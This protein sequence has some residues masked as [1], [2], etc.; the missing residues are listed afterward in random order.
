MMLGQG[1]E[2]Y[3]EELLRDPQCARERGSLV[4]AD[5]AGFRAVLGSALK[6]M[7]DQDPQWTQL[8]PSGICMEQALNLL[9]FPPQS[10]FDYSV[11]PIPRSD[12]PLLFAAAGRNVDLGEQETLR[13]QIAL[14][15]LEL[16]P[17]A[18]KPEYPNRDT[19]YP[20]AFE[21]GTQGTG[22]ILFSKRGHKE[23]V[24]F[25]SP[26]RPLCSLW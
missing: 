6:P 24:R 13:Q 14:R 1:R 12:V 16:N 5:M 8:W 22:P 3:D 18:A 25:C 20:R 26:P 15:Y 21:K 7:L 17:Q 4:S 9:L 11:P 2:K 23:P 19:H 10:R